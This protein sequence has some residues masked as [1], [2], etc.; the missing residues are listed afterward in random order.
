MRVRFEYHMV[1]V[2]EFSNPI[3]NTTGNLLIFQ[4]GRQVNFYLHPDDQTEFDAI[5]KSRGEIVIVPYY[6]NSNKISTVPDTLIRDATKEGSR[7]YL[8]RPQR[9]SG[10][11]IEVFRKKGFLVY[12]RG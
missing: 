9:S 3:G 11:K 6:H 4:M 5:L 10:V 2:D 1:I 8:V 7:V 12:R